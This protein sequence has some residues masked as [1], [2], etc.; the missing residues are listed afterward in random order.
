[1]FVMVFVEETNKMICD[2]F[3][4]SVGHKPISVIPGVGNVDPGG[5][6]SLQI[7]WPSR[8]SVPHP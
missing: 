5:P 7:E 4:L 1:M 3:F 8:T 2:V 6:V